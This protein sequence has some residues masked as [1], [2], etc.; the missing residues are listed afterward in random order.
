MSK[1][2]FNSVGENRRARAI[3]QQ[4]HSHIR[5]EARARERASA[6]GRIV[7]PSIGSA[8]G[9]ASEGWRSLT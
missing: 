4:Q 1:L 7:R 2:R 8:F 6:F 3:S 5:R 9:G